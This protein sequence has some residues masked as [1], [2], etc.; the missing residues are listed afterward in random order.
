LATNV[1]PEE[2]EALLGNSERAP[3]EVEARDFAVPRRLSARRIH[4]IQR[5]VRERL[6]RLEQQLQST[7]RE[8][9]TLV[10]N[11]LCETSAVGLFEELDLPIAMVRFSVDGQPGW[12]QWEVV[13]AIQT[14]EMV[15]GA[16]EPQD[17]VKRKLSHVES[18][19][20]QQ[21]LETIVRA[22]ADIAGVEIEGAFVVDQLES[23]GTW[24]DVG[25]NAD[26]Q[27]LMFDIEI[28]GPCGKSTLTLY[29][30][31]VIDTAPVGGALAD[32]LPTHL[33][34]VPVQL[35][36]QLGTIAV[37]LAELLRIEV[38]DVIPLA[39]RVGEPL[40]VS[41]DGRVCATARL[42][43]KNGALA[44]RVEDWIDAGSALEPLE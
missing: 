38:G 25:H 2:A 33:D 26:P 36:A 29:L 6:K 35:S 5:D 17:V 9:H 28:E 31:G 44:I 10:L 22:V 20:L 18:K 23:V 4:R 34:S 19:V 27:R 30:P 11:G 12:I 39:A 37:P 43:S 16:A 41:I 13:E 14:I 3:Q 24:E 42:G 32:V 7:L 40:D 8:P 15:L 1:E 21:I